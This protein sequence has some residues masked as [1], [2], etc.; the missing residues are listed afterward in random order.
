MAIDAIASSMAKETESSST[1]DAERTCSN[2]RN[3]EDK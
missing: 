1:V 2:E 3:R